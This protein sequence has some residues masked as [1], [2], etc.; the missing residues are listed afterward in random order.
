M[1][2]P[3]LFSEELVSLIDL[4]NTIR[5]NASEQHNGEKYVKR[6]SLIWNTKRHRREFLRV[7]IMTLAFLVGGPSNRRIL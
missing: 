2:E 5:W 3:K 6:K 1:I 7:K 4:F